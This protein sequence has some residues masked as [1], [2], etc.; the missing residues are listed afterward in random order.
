MWQ[1]IVI[2]AGS[3]VAIASLFP[4]LFDSDASVPHKTSIPTLL[5][6]SSQS[7]AFYTMD[8]MGSA[9]GAVAGFV[10]WTLI[11]YFKSP[12][13]PTQRSTPTQSSNAVPHAD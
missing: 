5:V 6:L 2:L 10:V 9:A 8:L 7:V 4:T 12:D 3:I 13:S 11:A 1:D